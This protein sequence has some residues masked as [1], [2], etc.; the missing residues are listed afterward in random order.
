MSYD[1]KPIIAENDFILL[2]PLRE[3]DA[4]R[5]DGMVDELFEIFNHP[6]MKKYS[7]E[8]YVTDKKKLE[9]KLM[10]VVMSYH[11]QLAY[12]HYITWKD[13]GEIIGQVDIITPKRAEDS[14]PIKDTWFI[15]YYLNKEH[16][17]YGMMTDVLKVVVYELRNQSIQKIGAICMPDNIAS[18]RVLEKSGFKRIGRFDA[19]QDFYALQ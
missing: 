4:L 11:M 13:T 1:L 7:P 9:A 8:K 18:I 6:S 19:L 2:H 10:G 12:T 16:W 3:K 15:E 17:G 5:T 14:Y